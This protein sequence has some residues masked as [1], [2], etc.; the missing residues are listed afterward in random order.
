MQRYSINATEKHDV[1]KTS[2]ILS[3]QGNSTNASS[4]VEAK[5]RAPNTNAG[6]LAKVIL[7]IKVILE[8]ESA[9]AS[10]LDFGEARNPRPLQDQLL[11][12]MERA[13]AVGAAKR[14]QA[15]YSEFRV[16]K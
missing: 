6:V 12:L 5:E 2:D 1:R 11:L 4:I 3:S 8:I 13:G 9:L 10:D 14:I 7:D 15:G 16:V